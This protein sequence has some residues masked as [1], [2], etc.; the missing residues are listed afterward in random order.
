MKRNIICFKCK[1]EIEDKFSFCPHCGGE[2]LKSPFK[3]ELPKPKEESKSIGWLGY[4]ILFSIF[5]FTYAVVTKEDPIPV[6]EEQL[7]TTIS[8]NLPNQV[9]EVD[10]IV[11]ELTLDAAPASGEKGSGMRI[12]IP[13]QSYGEENRYF[14]TS[15]HKVG[16]LHTITYTRVGNE[17][18]VFGKMEINCSKNKIRKTSTE[19]P[20]YLTSPD[21]DLGDWY[22]PTPDW[23]DNDIYN[24]ICNS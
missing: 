20:F 15:H 1:S 3:Q 9:T 5:F 24:F 8:Q 17:S 16:E 11:D 4:L 14:L 6:D 2:I 19:D 22:T 21:L 23:T 10:P 18:D 7:S 12:T 13:M